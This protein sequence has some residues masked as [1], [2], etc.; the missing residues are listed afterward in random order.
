MDGEGW[1][2]PIVPAAEAACTCCGGC[3]GTALPVPRRAAD[4]GIKA[5]TAPIGSILAAARPSPARSTPLL[6]ASALGSSR[7]ISEYSSKRRKRKIKLS[8]DKKKNYRNELTSFMKLHRSQLSGWK[9]ESRRLIKGTG[10]NAFIR[11]PI[12]EETNMH[13]GIR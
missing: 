13:P 5:F 9:E 8:K 12:G 7:A 3:C 11:H 6:T 10:S 1:T 2:A 4:P